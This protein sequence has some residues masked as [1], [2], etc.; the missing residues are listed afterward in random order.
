MLKTIAAV[1][2]I[3]FVPKSY[4]L[5]SQQEPAAS[6]SEL[7]YSSSSI[8]SPMDITRNPRHLAPD[9][10]YVGPASSDQSATATTS[11]R[12][13]TLDRAGNPINFNADLDQ[14]LK[15][16]I[17]NNN[18]HN[19][20]FEAKI[21]PNPPHHQAPAPRK[22]SRGKSRRTKTRP[23][24]N[25]IIYSLPE[26]SFYAAGNE[27]SSYS[28]PDSRESSGLRSDVGDEIPEEQPV[29]ADSKEFRTSSVP[30]NGLSQKKALLGQCMAQCIDAI[31]N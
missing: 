24:K 30:N 27:E 20:Q 15:L 10:Y 13:S 16:D 28:E 23:P 6:P 7:D 5:Q 22:P 12:T 11:L 26:Q 8:S 9:R 31:L 14:E 19:N 2:Q 21:L 17:S 29:E 3:H 18:P 4:F 25:V 1:Q